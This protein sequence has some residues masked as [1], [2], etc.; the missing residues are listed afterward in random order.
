MWWSVSCNN[1]NKS[2]TTEESV[3]NG[4]MGDDGNDQDRCS[5]PHLGPTIKLHGVLHC[6]QWGKLTLSCCVDLDNVVMAGL[7]LLHCAA[8]VDCRETKNGGQSD[9]KILKAYKFL[10]QQIL[11]FFFF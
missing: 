10:Y 4:R 6:L 3:V 9:V 1:V 2:Y 7:D 8:L 11:L 5:S